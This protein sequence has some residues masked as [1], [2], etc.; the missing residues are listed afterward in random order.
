MKHIALNIDD[1]YSK[2]C[3]VFL[4]SLFSN[5]IS[6][7]FT[8]HIL[9]D[10]VSSENKTKIESIVPSNSKIQFYDVSTN[11]LE[12]FP[13]SPQWPMTIYYRLLLPY[14]LPDNIEKI[15]YFDCDIIIRGSINQLWETNI[16]GVA[17]AAVEDMHSPISSMIEDLGYDSKYKYFNSGVLL[18]NINYWK[19]NKIA[20][21]CLTFIKEN[22]EII[23]HPDQ[24][25]LNAILH[26]K[27]KPLHYKW[28]FISNYQ[29][30]YFKEEHLKHDMEKKH[31]N[32]PVVIHFTGKKPWDSQCRTY[33][34][35]EF[36][37]YAK[38]T[39]WKLMPPKKKLIE[40]IKHQII[41]FLDKTRIKRHAIN[42]KY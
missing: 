39:P 7:K 33:Y 8:I 23:F 20:E 29:E 34:K 13:V 5:N 38:T 11:L 19:K 24:D 9:S 16:E 40:K 6:E 3:G 10:S 28:N 41:N 2:Y 32:F 15:L 37:D 21:K 26:D 27:W 17:I 36:F 25:A 1:K 42:Y 22:T 31:A 35:L 30:R 4:A 12:G 14:L 18:I